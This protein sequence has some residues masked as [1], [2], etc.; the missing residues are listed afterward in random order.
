MGLLRNLSGLTT[1]SLG[2]FYLTS[3]SNLSD[4]GAWIIIG[5]IFLS[6]C[7]WVSQAATKT[8]SK[9]A[10]KSAKQEVVE[11]TEATGE[12]ETNDD[13]PS[14]VKQENLDGVSLRERKLA[15][16]QAAASNQKTNL[17]NSQQMR[18]RQLR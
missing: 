17:W 18:S 10:S 6:S 13:I 2:V 5:A 3:A 8:D 15:K 12:P 4:D 7:V 14:P 11:E 9:I 1:V 16:I